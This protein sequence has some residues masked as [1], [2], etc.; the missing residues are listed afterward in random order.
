MHD[1]SIYARLFSYSSVDNLDK[2]LRQI[3]AP[4]I[5]IERLCVK[6]LKCHTFGDSNLI[7][8]VKPKI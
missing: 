2:P 4:A 8:S 6:A 1:S 7:C 5:F 3:T